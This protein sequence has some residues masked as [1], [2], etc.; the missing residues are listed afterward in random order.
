MSDQSKFEGYAHVEVMGHQSHTGMVTTEAFGAAVMLRIVTPEIPPLER[1]LEHAEY[2]DG[3][4]CY[5]GTVIEVS[6]P[7]KEVWVGAGSVYRLTP[8]SQEDVSRH[9]PMQKR[10]VKHIGHTSLLERPDGAGEGEF[11]TDDSDRIEP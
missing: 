1:T 6:S 4:Y 5:P 8:I 2:V 10:I 7:R 9:A 11:S 3:V